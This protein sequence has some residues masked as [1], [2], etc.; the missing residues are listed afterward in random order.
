MRDETKVELDHAS[1]GRSSRFVFVSR[2]VI[3]ECCDGC[4]AVAQDFVARWIAS[5]DDIA[6]RLS[7]RRP[8]PRATASAVAL[9]SGRSL[10]RLRALSHPCRLS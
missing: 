9:Q 8:R 3:I 4:A 7:A 5:H 6:R 2:R 10:A 1:V